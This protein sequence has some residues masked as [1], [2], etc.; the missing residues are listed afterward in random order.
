MITWVTLNYLYKY[1][2]ELKKDYI[3]IGFR[4]DLPN[5]NYQFLAN[6]N[7]IFY[8]RGNGKI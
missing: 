4:T 1:K 6:S 3:E 5:D 7:S 8:I 2:T